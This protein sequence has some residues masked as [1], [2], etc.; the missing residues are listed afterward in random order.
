MV[1]A[2]SVAVDW[3]G[4]GQHQVSPELDQVG[5][6]RITHCRLA[7]RRTAPGEPRAGPGGHATCLATHT[8]MYGPEAQMPEEDLYIRWAR[9]VLRLPI[10]ASTD[11]KLSCDRRPCT[12]VPRTLKLSLACGMWVQLTC[13]DWTP[14]GVAF[15]S[16]CLARKER[17]GS[18]GGAV[19]ND[20]PMAS[21]LHHAHM[22]STPGQVKCCF[23]PSMHDPCITS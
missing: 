2:A 7:W 22:E 8:R 12:R 14:S 17:H 23:R 16:V 5:T 10:H 18:A 1:L 20:L 19:G 13:A 6:L 21:A 11:L 15:P 4:E 3:P 9:Y